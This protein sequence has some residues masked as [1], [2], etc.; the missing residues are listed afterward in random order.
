MKTFLADVTF[1]RLDLHLSVRRTIRR[2]RTV[3]LTAK[4]KASKIWRLLRSG[5]AVLTLPYCR[6]SYKRKHKKPFALTAHAV[7]WK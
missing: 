7:H 1:H 4:T 5:L 2:M 6:M 3:R